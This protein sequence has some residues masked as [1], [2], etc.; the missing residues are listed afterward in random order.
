VDDEAR[1]V[2]FKREIARITTRLE[3]HGTIRPVRYVWNRRRRGKRGA[4][5][6]EIVLAQDEAGVYAGFDDAAESLLPAVGGAPPNLVAG[7]GF[8]PATF[9]L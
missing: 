3:W 1:I 7:A 6:G 8:E 2:E 4:T 9:G 5:F